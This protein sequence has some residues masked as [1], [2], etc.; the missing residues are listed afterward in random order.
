MECAP[1]TP[2]LSARKFADKL[3]DKSPSPVPN[4]GF[5]SG[6]P[7]SLS[8]LTGQSLRNLRQARAK[9]SQENTPP[10]VRQNSDESNNKRRHVHN[11]TVP[12]VPTTCLDNV[13][14][15]PLP[16]RS[17]ERPKRNP[18]SPAMSPPPM[19]P[20]A[21]KGCNSASPLHKQY[22]KGRYPDKFPMH[23]SM[24]GYNDEQKQFR[25]SSHSLDGELE[26]PQPNS[27][28]MQMSYPLVNVPPP[29]LQV[30]NDKRFLNDSL[31]RSMKR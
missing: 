9:T 4:T 3:T 23:Q 25:R 21:S 31:I 29:P 8:N 13:T 1:A 24:P 17:I 18:L 2:R 10:L 5:L 30:M 20:L 6:L 14:P 27:I 15:P 22:Y 16:P 11:N 28:A 19:N 12:M 26:G 7:R